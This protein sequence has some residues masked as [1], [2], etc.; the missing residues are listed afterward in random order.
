MLC[1]VMI[2]LQPRIIVIIDYF[3]NHSINSLVKKK[4]VKNALHNV[5]EPDVTSFCIVFLNLLS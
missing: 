3:H 4:N 5:Q 2:Q 1:Y